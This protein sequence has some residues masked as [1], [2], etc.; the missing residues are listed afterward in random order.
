[1]RMNIEISYVEITIRRGLRLKGEKYRARTN[2]CYKTHIH[3]NVTIKLCIAILTNKNV[4][5][6]K[7]RQGGKTGPVSS[8]Q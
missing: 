1:M 8:H 3:G 7:W 2:S 6:Q 4:F 5:F